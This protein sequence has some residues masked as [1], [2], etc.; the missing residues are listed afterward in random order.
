MRGQGIPLETKPDS[1][2]IEDFID[3]VID[4]LIPDTDLEYSEPKVGSINLK[5][6]QDLKSVLKDGIYGK[7][8]GRYNSQSRESVKD[9]K[10]QLA[11]LQAELK[12]RNET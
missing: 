10:A 11:G 8:W 12:K 6:R 3:E 7:L 2:A 4:D 9:L 5:N 1:R